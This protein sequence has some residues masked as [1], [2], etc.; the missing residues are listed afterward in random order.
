VPRKM[1]AKI[2]ER[3]ARLTLRHRARNSHGIRS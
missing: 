1:V 3:L 2:L